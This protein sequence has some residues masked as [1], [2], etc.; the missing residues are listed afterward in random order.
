MAKPKARHRSAPKRARPTA[1]KDRGKKPTGGTTP[2]A[3]ETR[4]PAFD[5]LWDA[6]G[7]YQ[8]TAALKAAIELDVFTAIAAGATTLEALAVR[9][10]AAERGLRALLGYLVADGFLTRTGD[11]YGLSPTAAV[12][13]DRNAPTYVGSA[14]GFLA[15][16]A[17]LEGFARLTD[18]VRL[19]ATAL[20]GDAALAPEHP[21]WIEFAKAMAPLA[22]TVARLLANLLG[23]E[24]LRGGSALD[25]AAGHGLYG[26]TLAQL[27]PRLEVTALDW[28]NVLAV[29]EENARRAGVAERFRTLAGNALEVP[30]GGPYDLV[31]VPNFLHHF[32][33]ATCERFLAKAH[34]ALS[35]GGRVVIVEFVPDEDRLGPPAAVRFSLVM[36]AATPGGDAYTF[37]EY[38][39]MLRRAGFARA[40]LH[41]LLPSPARVVLAAR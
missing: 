22:G 41:D 27:N 9:C 11:R 2:V 6:F 14:I 35:P 19:G 28:R 15:S 40:T 24:R 17:A 7:G 38:Q 23:V 12:F 33:P 21:M 1:R 3:K 39:A 18:A 26:I 13:L 34:A 32:D 25:V 37:S 5:V 36:L 31:L 8:R 4:G 29:A 20:P 30:L 10:Q 16:P